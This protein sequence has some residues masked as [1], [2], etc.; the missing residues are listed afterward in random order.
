MI[1]IYRRHHTYCSSL[2]NLTIRS[3]HRC[4][5]LHT[6]WFLRF[7][8]SS[9]FKITNFRI[10]IWKGCSINFA[11]MN[12]FKLRND[13]CDKWSKSAK[14][15]DHHHHFRFCYS[16]PPGDAPELYF[17]S[18][19]IEMISTLSSGLLASL[20]TLN[21]HPLKLITKTIIFCSQ[22]TRVSLVKERL[23]FK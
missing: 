15:I 9:N 10:I 5:L 8:V 12:S 14:K 16:K 17:V 21:E 6:G 20:R 22:R 4:G 2:E 23:N 19:R 3:R 1:A 11:L 18:Y 7:V 13:I